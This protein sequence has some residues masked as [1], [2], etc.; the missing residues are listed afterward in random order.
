M[1]LSPLT[2][3]SPID[4]RY[5]G[6]T[7]PL[8]ELFSEYALIRNRMTIEVRWLQCLA[9]DPRIGEVGPFSDRANCRLDKMLDKNLDKR[10][11]IL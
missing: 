2:A 8:R 1:D 10:Q 3:I 6:K 11:R 5:A 7:T 9:A 4:G